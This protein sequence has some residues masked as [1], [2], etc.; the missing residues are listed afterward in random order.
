MSH[1]YKIINN[2]NNKCYVGY[3]R[4]DNIKERFKEH[5]RDAKYYG[6][7]DNSILHNA[8]N[9]YGAE[10]FSIISLYK[11]DESKE[12]WAMLEKKYIKEQN[13]LFPNG[14]NILEGG[15]KPPSH[16]GNKKY[17]TKYPDEKMPI[18]YSMLA[19]NNFSYEKISQITGLSVQY[20]YLIN[21]GKYRYNPDIS[22]PIRKY[23]K[24]EEKAKKIINIL[25]TD[26]TLSNKKIAKKFNIR[27]NEVASI[28]H[29]K[30]YA[31]LWEKDFP[32][33]KVL[34][35]DNYEEKQQI[36]KKV[37]EYKKKNPKATNVA[38]QKACNISRSIYE[39]IIKNIY[40][41]NINV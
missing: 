38:I 24:F 33:R 22:Y 39:K 4:R 40:P 13:C 19:D 28:N 32:I 15:N 29:G 7:S 23:N 34:V 6:N 18:L 14:Y 21:M 11:F 2:I 1:I 26:K 16:Y 30:K 35:P 36:A 25:A 27:P 9:K 17:K 5:C 10:N 37:L 12:D 8:I 41:Y 20:L 31:Y 3:T